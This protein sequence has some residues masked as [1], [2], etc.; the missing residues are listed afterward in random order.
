VKATRILGFLILGLVALAVLLVLTTFLVNRN[1]EPPSAA[2]LR[3]EKILISRPE[4]PAS[5]NAVVYALGFNVPESMDPVKVGAER[6]Q[7]IISF[8]DT[9]PPEQGDP[10]GNITSFLDSASADLIRLKE[11]C[12]GDDRPSCAREFLAV[13]PRW[14][15]DEQEQLALRRYQELL[16]RHA[17]RDV[18]PQH[19]SAP[20]PP[21]GDI[22][23]AQRLYSLQLMQLALAG[24]VDEVRARL[25]A[26]FRHWRGAQL[27]ATS[28]IANMIAIAALRNHFFYATLALRELPVEAA[29]RVVPEDWKREVSDE[30]RSMLRV[31]AGEYAF[32][33]H[34]MVLTH[35]GR[36]SS[37]ADDFEKERT[38]LNKW[39]KTTLLGLIQVQAMANFYADRYTR[40]SDAFAVPMSDYGRAEESYLASLRAEKHSW[41]LHN[42]ALEFFRSRDDGTAYLDYPFRVASLEGMRRAALLTVQLRA[43]GVAPGGMPSAVAESSLRDPFTGNAF[44]WNTG[45]HSLVFKA[46][47]N[48]AWRRIEYLY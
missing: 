38:A 33:R 27:S 12:S 6:M 37:D 25:D 31:M 28:L 48:H 3:F 39:I 34:L 42:P 41:S 5:E 36:Y 24:Q 15:P 17:W 20:L 32:V 2:A 10:A 26:E 46:P 1:D 9:G 35:S 18:V 22:I 19:L 16:L 11:A 40:L 21:Y 45:S 23:H 44:E 7:W 29:E 8:G 13:A 4:L 47:E 14:R 30:E 43:A